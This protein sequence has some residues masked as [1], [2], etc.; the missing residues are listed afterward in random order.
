MSKVMIVT[1]ASR[2]IG[3]AIARRAAKE[4]Y[5]VAVNYV[6]SKADADKV[7]A[8]ITGAGGKAVAIQADVSKEAD[9]IRLFKETDEKLGRVDALINNAGIVV[10]MCRADSMTAEILEKIFAANVFSVFYCTREALKRMSTKNGGKGGAII[11]MSS[12]AAR[13]GGLPEESHYAASKGALDSMVAALAREVGTEGVRVIGVRPGLI[14]TEIHNAH[15]G[16]ALLDKAGPTVPIGRAGRP[17]EVA[18]VVVWL[19]TDAA[20][21]IHGTMIDVSGGR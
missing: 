9:V 20:S 16:Q 2:G 15:G 5:A 19:T 12:A 6:S 8:E 11:Q 14:T 10:R 21:Y 17:E 4:G 1:G 3:A 13:H 18:E 7:V